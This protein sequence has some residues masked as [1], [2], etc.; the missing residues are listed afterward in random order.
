MFQDNITGNSIEI[1]NYKKQPI[2]IAKLD[3]HSKLEC[4][5][6]ASNFKTFKLFWNISYR[7]SEFLSFE[8]ELRNRVTQNDVTLRVTDS[9]IFI[10]ILFSSYLL[11]FVKY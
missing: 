10:E 1:R 9:K 8:I 7:G 2:V 5:E 11:E 4:F 6:K 3:R